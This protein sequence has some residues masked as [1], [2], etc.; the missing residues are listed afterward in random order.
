MAGLQAAL[1]FHRSLG[2]EQVWH[3]VR[4]LQERLRT[5]LSSI[6]RMSLRS[7][8]PT[9]TAGML[10]FRIEGLDALALQGHL[11][12]TARIR[13]RVIGEYGLGWMRLS[14]HVYNEP[15]ELDRVLE[16]LDAAA[17]RGLG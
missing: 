7:P 15:G 16:L 12:R 9:G 3:R 1:E 11:A 14:T 5:G 4:E 13:T 6:P 8:E 10:S 17:R 2:P